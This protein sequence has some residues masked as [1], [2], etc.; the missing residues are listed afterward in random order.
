MRADPNLS[1]Y[2]PVQDRP[3]IAWPDGKKLAFWV[4]PNIEFYEFQPPVNPS[5]PGW[6]KPS[7]PWMPRSTACWPR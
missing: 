4:A 6:P 5:R 2:W 7:M 3:K 1:D